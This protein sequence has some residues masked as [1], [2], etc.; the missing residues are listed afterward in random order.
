LVNFEQTKI[1]KYEYPGVMLFMEGGC[2]AWTKPYQEK[3]C[4]M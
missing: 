4:N 3:L 1:T 2:N